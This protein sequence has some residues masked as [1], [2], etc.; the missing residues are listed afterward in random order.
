MIPIL[1]FI[2]GSIFGSF[3]HVLAERY[4]SPTSAFSGRSQCP[5]CKKTLTPSE[6]IPIVSYV[7]SK[8]KCRGCSEQISV[9]YPITEL[10]S[11]MLA[12]LL[13]APPFIVH[14]SFLIPTL[15]YIVACILI[16]LIR[17]DSRL[18]VL[19]DGYIVLL[20]VI[21]TLRM[22]VSGGSLDDA[23]LGALVGSMTIYVI[24]SV[25][26]GRGIGFGDV[27]LMIPLGII[28]GLR[29]SITLLFIAFCIGGFVGTF[30]LVTKRA[31]GKTAIPFGPFLAGAA[32]ILLLAPFVSDRFFAFLGV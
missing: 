1:L 31:T 13:L 27:K 22:I 25:T 7:L 29:G 15:A 30:L 5:H 32:L 12:A 24:W 23:L 2:S 6:L 4:G 26:G 20:T 17:I 18:M 14:T 3:L 11:G 19:P 10:L 9:H 28:F 8:G 21:A 16:V